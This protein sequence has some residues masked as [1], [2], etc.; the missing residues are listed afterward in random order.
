MNKRKYQQLQPEERI[1]IASMKQLGLSVQAMARTLGR[2][3]STVSRELARNA[4][5]VRGYASMPAQVISSNRRAAARAPRKLDL[6]GALWRIVLSLL[7]WKW[8]PQQISGTLKRMV[9]CDV[10]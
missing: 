8:S 9:R 2:S 4:C 6:H 3:A 5:P 7:S 10:A 1:T